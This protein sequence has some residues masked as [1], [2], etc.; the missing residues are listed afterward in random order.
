MSSFLSIS[1]FSNLRSQSHN[2]INYPQVLLRRE[3]K[4]F[5]Q[6][7]WLINQQNTYFRDRR[8]HIF[9]MQI[10]EVKFLDK[11]AKVF[12]PIVSSPLPFSSLCLKK[13][14]VQN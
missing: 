5:C 4:D 8:Q 14:L 10:V 13:Y 2:E 3:F 1:L 11:K 12:V 6:R 9:D 7:C